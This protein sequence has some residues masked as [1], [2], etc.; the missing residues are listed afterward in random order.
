M[1]LKTYKK[2]LPINVLEHTKHI[3]KETYE[4]FD[5]KCYVAVSGGKDSIALLHLC[6]E[7]TQKRVKAFCCIDEFI[8]P[9]VYKAL[10][11]LQKDDRF[12]LLFLIY[13]NHEMMLFR[14]GIIQSTVSWDK[15]RKFY[16]QPKPENHLEIPKGK[17]HWEVCENH[18]GFRGCISYMVGVRA[19]ESIQRDINIYRAGKIKTKD[20]ID[21]YKYRYKIKPMYHWKTDDIFKYLSEQK[22][23]DELT[24]FYFKKM[25][26]GQNTMRMGS[27]LGDFIKDIDFY[28]TCLLYTSDAADE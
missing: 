7:V 26:L 18:W 23:A 16:L 14:N 1:G 17:F 8:P 6:H 4:E 5:G 2:L 28:R 11:T 20:D 25:Y 15:N 27:L 24:E 10:I 19:T 22:G 12:D 3:I 21:G 9:D 13:P